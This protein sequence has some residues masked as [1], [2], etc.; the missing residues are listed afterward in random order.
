MIGLMKLLVCFP[1]AGDGT[2]FGGTLFKPFLDATE[3]VFIELAKEP[4]FRLLKNLNIH[5]YLKYRLYRNLLE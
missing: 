2:R 1:M 3:K 5:M 4:S